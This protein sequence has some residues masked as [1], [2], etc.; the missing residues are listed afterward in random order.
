VYIEFVNLNPNFLVPS[1]EDNGITDIG[2]PF[3]S[4]STQKLT[5]YYD[6][7]PLEEA[8]VFI[9]RAYAT[10]ILDDTEQ[11]LIKSD[12]VYKN[13]NKTNGLSYRV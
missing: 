11:Y 12:L 9:T 10:Q 6:K 5:F 8:V 2:Q 4:S 13:K 1:E 7:L 3:S